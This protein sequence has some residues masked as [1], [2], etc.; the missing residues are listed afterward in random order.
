MT[1]ANF[2]IDGKSPVSEM[3][4]INCK[5]IWSADSGRCLGCWLWMSSGPHAV[6]YALS[7]DFLMSSNENGRLYSSKVFDLKFNLVCSF[8]AFKIVEILDGTV[9]HSGTPELTIG[10]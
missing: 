5:R 7:N 8:F 1:L 2:Q 6:A 9:Y 3:S 10:F 4:F